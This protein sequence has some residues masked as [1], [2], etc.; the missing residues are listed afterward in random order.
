MP[1]PPTPNRPLNAPA[2]IAITARRGRLLGMGGHT[3]ARA[4]PHGR[5]PCPDARA[6]DTSA[7]PSGPLLRRRRHARADRGAARGL[8]RAGE[9]VPPARRAGPPLRDRRVRLGTPGG[10]GAAPRGSGQPR[11]SAPPPPG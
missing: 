3:T 5:D 6:P 7:R 10:G 9:D 2:T 4:S 11:L 8:S 1:P